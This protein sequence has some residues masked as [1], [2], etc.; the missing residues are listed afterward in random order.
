MVEKRKAVS[1]M[2]QDHYDD[3]TPYLNRCEMPHFLTPKIQAL[4]INGLRIKD[5]GGPGFSNLEAGAIALEMSK[6]DAS[7]STFYL[8]HNAIGTAV[9]SA[10][11]DEE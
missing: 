5:H 7:V 3:L 10:L 2:M 1:K 11:G 8:V 9:I 6:Y 4:G